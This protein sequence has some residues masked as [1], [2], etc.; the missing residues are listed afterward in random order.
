MPISFIPDSNQNQTNLNH[1]RRRDKIVRRRKWKCM[2][3]RKRRHRNGR[4]RRNRRRGYNVLNRT[5]LTKETDS[6]RKT[7]NTSDIQTP[8]LPVSKRIRNRCFYKRKRMRMKRK[9]HRIIRRRRRRWRRARKLL[10]RSDREEKKNR[11]EEKNALSPLIEE[12]GVT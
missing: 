5:K 12:D 6:V 2:R 10:N 11:S 4:R 1:E 8:K 7:G 3:N 9:F